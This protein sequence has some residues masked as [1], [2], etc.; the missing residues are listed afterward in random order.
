MINR[1]LARYIDTNSNASIFAD[2]PSNT[3][4]GPNQPAPQQQRTIDV[5]PSMYSPQTPLPPT[6]SEANNNASSTHFESPVPEPI[7]EFPPKATAVVSQTQTSETS[8][9]T[10][11]GYGAVK[12]PEEHTQETSKQPEL[13]F[14][15]LP[16]PLEIT[17]DKSKNSPGK[18][19]TVGIGM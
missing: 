3:V 18:L 2:V 13:L 4:T 9:D 10:T 12:T 8:I 7:T 5:V 16:E 15:R 6:I 11:V 19:S 14:S 1:K 17:S